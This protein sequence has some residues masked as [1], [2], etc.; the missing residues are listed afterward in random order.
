MNDLAHSQNKQKDDGYAVGE[1][2]VTVGRG[3][4][5]GNAHGPFLLRT[6]P[7]VAT[8]DFDNDDNDIELGPRR[9]RPESLQSCFAACG[10]SWKR[11]NTSDKFI[12]VGMIVVGV[13]LVVGGTI[14]MINRNGGCWT[15]PTS[16]HIQS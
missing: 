4:V 14:L 13:G 1:E 8:G 5:P 16:P 2:I 11:S 6:F 3:I 7:N 9:G 10:D 12:C 15:R